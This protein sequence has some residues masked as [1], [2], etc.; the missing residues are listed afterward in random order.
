MGRLRLER[1]LFDSVTAMRSRQRTLRSREEE[2][3]KLQNFRI[4]MKIRALAG[5]GEEMGKQYAATIRAL[6]L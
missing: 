5:E 1:S 2:A 6:M 4:A 3:E